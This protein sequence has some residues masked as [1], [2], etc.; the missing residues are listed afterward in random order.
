[1]SNTMMMHD[2]LHPG[3][4]LKEDFIEPLLA[5]H[6]GLSIA[7]VAKNLGVNRNTLFNL[8]QG[9]TGISPAM[10]VR[11][12]K[13]FP[14]TDAEFWLNLQKMYDL[15]QAKQQVDVESIHSYQDYQLAAI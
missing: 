8:M 7:Q 10:A 3:E 12:E 14:N 9:Q 4:L 15:W 11:L 5:N 1:M 2:P 13:A 6:T